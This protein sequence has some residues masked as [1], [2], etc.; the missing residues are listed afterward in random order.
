MDR[1]CLLW[2]RYKGDGGRP[3]TTALANNNLKHNHTA[4]SGGGSSITA[5][6]NM[7]RAETFDNGSTRST[8]ANLSSSAAAAAA[9]AATSAAATAAN[10]HQYEY[11][12][13]LTTT[14]PHITHQQPQQQQGDYHAVFSEAGIDSLVPGKKLRQ[15]QNNTAVTDSSRQTAI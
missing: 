15:Q 14:T 7:V 12:E 2:F 13:L 1:F 8:T 9:T 10:H 4:A 6:Y 11:H 3:V 5:P